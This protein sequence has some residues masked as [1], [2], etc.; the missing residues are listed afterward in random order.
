MPTFRKSGV[1]CSAVLLGLLGFI[2]PALSETAI[3]QQSMTT[4]RGVAEAYQPGSG[5]PVGK[6]QS[7]RGD[8]VV[9]H[10]DPTVAY[11][12]EA[13]L[14]I[15]PG[16]TISTRRTG[17]ILCQ[18][19]DG[20]RFFLTMA[21]TLKILQCNYNA[22]RQAGVSFLSLQQGGARFQVQA[23]EGVEAYAFKVQTQTAFIETR[24]ADF[25]VQARVQ[26]T[27]VMTLAGSRLEIT[28]LADPEEV[29]FLSAFQQAMVTAQSPVPMVET[30]SPQGA[31]ALKARFELY[32]GPADQ[33]P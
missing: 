28:A 6:V 7:V 30:L 4:N 3:A 8:T 2:R 31:Q 15:Y 5:L 27:T 32:P 13:G 21:S 10:R 12:V 33:T 17:R 29:T 18:L 16:D 20:S 24:A 22:S 23:P 26:S 11:R 25:V 9:Y 1:Y 19:V 14:P